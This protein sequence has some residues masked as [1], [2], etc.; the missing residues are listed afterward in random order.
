MSNVD[1][2]EHD[3]PGSGC[4]E[5]RA[6]ALARKITAPSGTPEMPVKAYYHEW[7]DLEGVRTRSVGLEVRKEFTDAP[8]VLESD[9]MECITCLEGEIAKRDA[10]IVELESDLA[11]TQ[12][13]VLSLQDQWR[14]LDAELAALKVQYQRDVYGLNNEGDPIGG[15]PAGGYANDNARL[16]AELAAIKAQEPVAWAGVIEDCASLF[17]TEPKLW[18]AIPL[19]AAPA[20]EAKA[21][22]VVLQELLSFEKWWCSTPILRESKRTIAEKAW[23][24]ARI[25]AAPAAPVSAQAE[26]KAQ[27]FD[28][29]VCDYCNAETQDPWHGSG[30]LN[31]VESRHIHAC[32]QC[33]NL[34]PTAKAQG[35][36]QWP[37]ADEIMQM[38]F[39]EGHPADDASGYYFELEEF[40]LFIDRLMSE[41]AR[42]NAAPV[43]QPKCKTCDDNGRIGGPSFYAPDEG[44]EP[45]PD[46]SAPVQQVSVP[47]ERIIPTSAELIQ[48]AWEEEPEETRFQEG[49]NAAK[50]WVKM[51]IEAGIAA[52]AAPAADAG[53][54][55]EQAMYTLIS[56]GYHENSGLVHELRQALAAHRAKGVV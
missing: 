1:M 43:Q 9:A 45:C 33:R 49:Y 26:A 30:M 46:C 18:K 52:P 13:R 34:L 47:D 56:I 51:Q 23:R 44:G 35:V 25:A 11:G 20:S 7:T 28:P 10:R 31:G 42:L 37:E 39:E 17:V 27:D 5:C 32:S 48:W 54:V 4:K 16:R 40:D 12:S 29:L 22:D 2:C 24:A 50:R 14:K 21:Q 41:V 38:A 3:W 8:L 19:Y 36:V 6:E 15:E 55:L 53:C